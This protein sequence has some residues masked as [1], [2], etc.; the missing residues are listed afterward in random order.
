MVDLSPQVDYYHMTQR[1]T[2]NY[3]VG[4]LSVT[5]S[6]LHHIVRLFSMTQ[7]PQAKKDTLIRYII[8]KVTKD[9]FPESKGKGQTHLFFCFTRLNSTC[10]SRLCHFKVLLGIIHFP[11]SLK[12]LSAEFSSLWTLGLRATVPHWLLASLPS[13]FATWLSLKWQFTSQSEEGK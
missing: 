5:S 7:G 12:W 10:L 13:V 6:T 8:P 11:N 1:L 9:Y 2:L 3:N 4:L